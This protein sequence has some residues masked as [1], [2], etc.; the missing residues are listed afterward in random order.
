MVNQISFLETLR[1]LRQLTKDTFKKT[2][3][4]EFKK[5]RQIFAMK[6]W[7]FHMISMFSRIISTSFNSDTWQKAYKNREEAGNPEYNKEFVDAS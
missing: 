3:R 6:S 1:W 5:L 2:T 7:V 4:L